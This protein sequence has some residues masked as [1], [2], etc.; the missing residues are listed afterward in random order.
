[1]DSRYNQQKFRLTNSK[2]KNIFYIVEGKATQSAVLRQNAIDT[3]ILNTQILNGFKVRTTVNLQET[4]R[5][6]SSMHYSIEKAI[7][8]EL[9]NTEK[10][11]FEFQYNYDE[12]ELL[13]SKSNC[14]NTRILFG[15]MM[16]H[17]KGCGKEAVAEIL[18]KFD[19]FYDFYKHINSKPD[20]ASR[21]EFLG[22]K[23]KKSKK[24]KNVIEIVDP[25]QVHVNKTV[26]SYI[27]TVFCEERY[28]KVISK[29]TQKFHEDSSDI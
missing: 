25:L 21:L 19:T 11:Y 18:D 17:I 12:F 22:Q 4:I 8:Q 2:I 15:N 20:E 10:E 27:S 5:L 24:N 16:R 13:T 9:T 7:L 1:M 3:A 26:A 14:L 29:D 23:Q 28:P 6:I